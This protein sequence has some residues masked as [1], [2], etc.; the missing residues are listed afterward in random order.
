VCNGFPWPLV[1]DFIP[2]HTPTCT[3]ELRGLV[4]TALAW[5]KLMTE[6]D[7]PFG[8]PNLARFGPWQQ[9][10]DEAET[11]LRGRIARFRRGGKKR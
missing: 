5:E 6:G 11:R 4:R 3:P 2:K 8:R 10:M 1:T 9:E 7:K